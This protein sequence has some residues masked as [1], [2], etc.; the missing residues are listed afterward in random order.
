[1]L[2]KQRRCIKKSRAAKLKMERFMMRESSGFTPAKSSM[3]VVPDELLPRDVMDVQSTVDDEVK[4]PVGN[5]LMEQ[6]VKKDVR[7]AQVVQVVSVEMESGA[8]QRSEEVPPEDIVI[9]YH[10][11]VRDGALPERFECE[12]ATLARVI[13]PAQDG[14]LRTRG[15]GSLASRPG[16]EEAREGEGH[17]L[18]VQRESDGGSTE[19]GWRGRSSTALQ[20]GGTPKR[21]SGRGGCRY[22][23]TWCVI[24]PRRW[25]TSN[26]TAGK[27]RS[28]GRR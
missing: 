24:R 11:L 4:A 19:R 17:S 2:K 8:L 22:W 14:E 18:S 20:P 21:R 5:K 23:L 27:R 15:G 6:T 1:M 10:T 28:P 13:E 26:G 25:G 3:D 16:E 9:L 7:D 12:L